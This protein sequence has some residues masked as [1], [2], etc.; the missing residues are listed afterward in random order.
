MKNHSIEHATKMLEPTD[1][2]GLQKLMEAKRELQSLQKLHI[3]I[4]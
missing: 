2:Q 3:S 4:E 1:I